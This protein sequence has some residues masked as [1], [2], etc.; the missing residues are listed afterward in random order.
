MSDEDVTFVQRPGAAAGLH[1]PPKTG[2][3]P[4]K[5]EPRE[6]VTVRLIGGPHHD[7]RVDVWVNLKKIK[8]P[9]IRSGGATPAAPETQETI[10]PQTGA[11][12]VK[13]NRQ[14]AEAV[15]VY[16]VYM[17]RDRRAKSARFTDY[18]EED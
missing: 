14:V 13:T 12:I 2:G 4:Q 18:E 10:D 17:R 7:Q 3:I 15:A 1:Q 11:L 9:V 16:A 6:L 5:A 8:L